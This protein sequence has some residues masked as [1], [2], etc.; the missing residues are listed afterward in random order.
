MEQLAVFGES[1]LCTLTTV[2]NSCMAETR[3]NTLGRLHGR[4]ALKGRVS[5]DARQHHNQF[6]ANCEMD[7]FIRV[8]MYELHGTG[9]GPAL[10]LVQTNFSRQI[11]FKI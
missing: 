2:K 1:D 5:T 7:A 3:W 11:R 9:P 8:H 4:T 6:F 10:D